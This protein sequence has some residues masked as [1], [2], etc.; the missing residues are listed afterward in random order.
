[1]A[2]S[3]AGG[4]IS[5]QLGD[6]TTGGRAEPALVIGL[7][8]GITAISAGVTHA[9]ALDAAGGVWC[10]GANFYSQLGDGTTDQSSVPVAADLGEAASAIGAGNW[11]TCAL[12]QTGGL[13]CWG[14]NNYGQLGNS[15]WDNSPTSQDVTDLT[16]GVV[17]FSSGLRHNCAR[18]LGRRAQMLGA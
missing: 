15:T 18:R 9:C 6:G 14:R 2:T 12:T 8:A 13:Q 17:S 11:H 4:S 1:M 5:G 7:P 3:S 16:G 10:W